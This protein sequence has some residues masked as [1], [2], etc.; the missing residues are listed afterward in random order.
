MYAF[1]ART[2][3]I[4]AVAKPENAMAACV[5]YL[6]NSRSISYYDTVYSAE[7]I[8]ERRYNDLTGILVDSFTKWTENFF[9][10]IV[11]WRTAIFS[12]LTMIAFS[13]V[14]SCR[15]GINCWLPFVPI[16]CNN[17]ILFAST[18]SPDYRYYWPSVV[19]GL[20]LFLLSPSFLKM[21]NA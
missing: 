6:G 2:Q 5:N 17:L 16:L 9:L 1:L 13:V 18:G 20:F 14:I 12:I 21:N 11:F 15:K 4:W 8:T 10:N 3:Y 7:E 19:L